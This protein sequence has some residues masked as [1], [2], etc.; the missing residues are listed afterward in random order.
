MAI[1]L[2][3]LWK[4]RSYEEAEF[5]P[6]P[7]TTLVLGFN[8]A[9]K[10]SLIEATALFATLSSPRTSHLA[11][12]VKDAQPE[13]G[14]RLETSS[15]SELEFRIRGGRALLRAQGSGVAAKNFLG[16]FRAV[17]FGPEDL[18]LV[19][20]EPDLRRRALD[21]LLTQ[22]RPSYRAL[23][24]DYDRALRQRNAALRQG[25]AL[26]AAMFD[27]PLAATG[28]Q[29]LD[30][31]RR[32][33]SDLAPA[34]TDL[35]ELLSGAGTATV[36]YRNSTTEH[37]L[38]GHDLEAHLLEVYSSTIQVDLER[39]TT[40]VGP[41]RDDLEIEVDGLAARS[42]SSRGEQ[43]SA[44]LSL[45]LAELRL[46]EDPVLLLDDVLSEL[47]PDR[48]ARVFKV[49]GECQ[50]ILTATDPASVPE[51]APVDSVWRVSEGRLHE[52]A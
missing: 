46:L 14:A 51:S 18:D 11:Q 30:A 23:R 12:L 15:G 3:R 50:V 2:L 43:R 27:A 47:D 16:R 44:A 22:L 6:S 8:G 1:S 37:E 42:Y 49:V 21:D 25:A 26:E 10:S 24:S 19:R 35:Y 39:G 41:H 17:V 45:R 52:A 4:L 36:R 28:A 20:G 5:K 29:I 7:S 31:R 48:R 32:L 38:S 40:R 34:V 33:I 9:G 13:G